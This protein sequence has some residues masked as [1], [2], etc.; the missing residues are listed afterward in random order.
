MNFTI[1]YKTLAYTF[2]DLSTVLQRSFSDQLPLFFRT[3][4]KTSSSSSK[5]SHHHQ[6][7]ANVIGTLSIVGLVSQPVDLSIDLEYLTHAQAALG[8][9][10]SDNEIHIEVRAFSFT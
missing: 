2:I 9:D 10:Y 5:S 7:A 1:G 6:R 3:N 4:T 8:S